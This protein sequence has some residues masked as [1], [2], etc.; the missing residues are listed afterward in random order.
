MGQVPG[1]LEP[2]PLTFLHKNM[3]A[4][5]PTYFFKYMSSGVVPL[6][7]QNRTLRWSTP[8]LLND[9]FDMQ[10]DL[11]VE[12]DR[13][14]L[15][16]L[17]LRKHWDAWYGPS[18]VPHPDSKMG[19][20]I[21]SNRHRAPKLSREAFAEKFHNMSDN[22]LDNLISHL[23]ERHKEVR[24]S[25]ATTKVLCLSAVGDSLPMWA[26]YAENHQG[27]VLRFKRHSDVDSLYPLAR[28]VT[29]TQQMP[30]LFDEERLSDIG[31][32]LATTQSPDLIERLVYTKAKAWEHEQEWRLF[33]GQGRAPG[34]PVEYIP[35]FALELD[36]VILGCAMTDD[37]RM[38][39]ADLTRSLYPHT[40]VLQAAKS[41]RDFK[42]VIPE[43]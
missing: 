36:A 12:V 41:D 7:L 21:S 31:A 6:V 4:A 5:R 43:A 9:P 30:R 25:I 19:K 28:A 40:K 42:L 1:T 24:A 18:Y 39:V 13:E 34:D 22:S 8:G 3:E 15:R 17:T 32:G 14:K 35:F 11:H 26:Y 27:A 33:L 2:H 23:P 20:F 37:C 16:A 38:A 10:F 29:Y